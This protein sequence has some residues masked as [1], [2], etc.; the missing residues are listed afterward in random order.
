MSTGYN[1]ADAS[2]RKTKALPNGIGAVNS[3]GIDAGRLTS[4][5]SVVAPCELLISGPI[6][7]TAELP[8]T[9]TIKYDVQ[10]DADSAFGSPRT[11]AKEVLVQTGAG[12]AGAAAA[13][14]R[15]R[16]PTDC[17]QYV[18]VVATNDATGNASGKSLT[19]ALLF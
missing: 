9:K 3:D 2:L 6:L 18:R 11:L 16:L 12:A 13:E 10:C 1:A 19:M 8:D 7:T 14:A 5:G 17:E 4:K 15:F